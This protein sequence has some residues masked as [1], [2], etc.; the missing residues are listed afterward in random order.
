ME[1]C[2]L[3]SEIFL[4]KKKKKELESLALTAGNCS[5]LE[6]CVGGGTDVANNSTWDVTSKTQNAGC[7]T[8]QSQLVLPTRRLQGVKKE[9]EKESKYF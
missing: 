8:G 3:T 7:P 2:H 5:L 4:P 6:T 9:R 1:V